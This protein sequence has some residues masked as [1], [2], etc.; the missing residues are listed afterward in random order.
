MGGMLMS[1]QVRELQNTQPHL[2]Q[3]LLPRTVAIITVKGIP[4]ML[5]MVKDLKLNIPAPTGIA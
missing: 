2:K 3:Q 1:V 4:G 5:R